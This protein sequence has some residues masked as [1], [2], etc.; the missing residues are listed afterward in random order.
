MEMLVGLKTITVYLDSKE[1]AVSVTKAAV[2]VAEKF[3]AHV[4]GLFVTPMTP[5]YLCS[6]PTSVPV[7]TENYLL[8]TYKEA[9]AVI[10]TVFELET[11]GRSLVAEWREIRALAS[12]HR[13]IASCSQTSDLLVTGAD[14]QHDPDGL[15]E[16]RI[17]TIIGASQRPLLTVPAH[18]EFEHIGNRVLIA[19]D[20]SVECTRA[21]FGALPLL[22]CADGV[23][24]LMINPANDERHQVF[25]TQAELVNS[26][27]RHGVSA[28]L[29]FTTCAA[30]QVAD[31]IINTATE[32]SADL[33][34]M[35]AY[36]ASRLHDFFAGS[37]TRNTLA[38]A[39][40]PLLM[41]H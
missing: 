23:D 7:Y 25:G 37:V 26:L 11:A 29:C 41:S 34:V 36:G 17:S 15:A 35:G 6:G 3:E 10:K 21:V 24:I 4:I 13:T 8:E 39:T 12:I 38:N 31:E 1:T 18:L 9:E 5:I 2:A 30:T 14:F 40:L 19:W 33:I 27:A 22:K 28:E 16:D 32:K 20:G